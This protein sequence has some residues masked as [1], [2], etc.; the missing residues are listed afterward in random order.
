MDELVGYLLSLADSIG[1]Q[2]EERI[3]SANRKLNGN[4]SILERDLTQPIRINLEMHGGERGN[5]HDKGPHAHVW[6]G[7]RHNFV[8]DL[9]TFELH[10]SPYE[11]QTSREMVL[12]NLNSS[13]RT[14][15]RK[16]WT[17]L[18]GESRILLGESS[19]NETPR[20]E[21]L[22]FQSP[23]HT[24]AGRAVLEVEFFSSEDRF[25]LHFAV[26]SK[27]GVAVY[28]HDERGC[29]HKAAHLH[30]RFSGEERSLDLK[31]FAKIAGHAEVPIKVKKLMDEL[32]P[33]R[34]ELEWIWKDAMKGNDAAARDR[35]R[36]LD[37]P[38]RWRHGNH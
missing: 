6:M 9:G 34:Q 33:L 2:Q 23:R 22:L 25:V 21:N 5:C 37:L 11:S 36:K 24:R 35:A 8:I 10:H 1:V 13:T 29:R 26:A 17:Q 4:F 38:P 3:E 31:T 15:L 7:Y 16:F 28:L 32:L 12:R 20:Y 30:V 14:K 18:N 19:E 27:N